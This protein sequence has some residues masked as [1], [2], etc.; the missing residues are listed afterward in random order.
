VTAPDPLDELAAALARLGGHLDA[1]AA[2]L[3][4]ER[5]SIVGVAAVLDDAGGSAGGQADGGRGVV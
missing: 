1:L 2:E 5:S 4:A 3:A